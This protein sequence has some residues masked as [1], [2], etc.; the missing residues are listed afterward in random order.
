MCVYLRDFLCWRICLS[1][2]KTC[3]YESL[4]G[5]SAAGDFFFRSSSEGDFFFCRSSSAGDFLFQATQAFFFC[6][7][8]QA[9]FFFCLFVYLTFLSIC[10]M[11][12]FLSILSIY[13]NTSSFLFLYVYLRKI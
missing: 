10:N 3:L 1:E 9:N 5:S 2:V 4:F 7:A 6:Q 8:P 13:L 12:K 11:F